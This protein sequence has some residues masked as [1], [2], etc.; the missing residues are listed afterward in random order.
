MKTTPG[1]WIEHSVCWEDADQKLVKPIITENDNLT[2]KRLIALVRVCG[3]RKEDG[4]FNAR[5]IAAAPEL[6]EACKELVKEIRNNYNVIHMQ[7][8]EYG[9]WHR[10]MS[11]IDKAEGRDEG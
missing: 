8:P 1:P 5:L 11:A 6:L 4:P 3:C 10:A 9:I 2:G 7:G